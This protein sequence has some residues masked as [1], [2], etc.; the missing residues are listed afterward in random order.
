MRKTWR[1]RGW[2]RHR[3]A[4]R[5]KKREAKGQR[6]KKEDMSQKGRDGDMETGRKRNREVR[7]KTWRQRGRKRDMYMYA[8]RLRDLQSKSYWVREGDIEAD[9]Q[10][11]KHGSREAGGTDEDWQRGRKGNMD[12]E[13]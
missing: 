10:G 13:R 4:E 2:K 11:G 8:G 6:V 3:T 9:T 12:A 1:Q 5:N 7:R